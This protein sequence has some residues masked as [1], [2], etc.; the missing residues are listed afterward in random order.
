MGN[1]I[2]ISE[3]WT[4]KLSPLKNHDIIWFYIFL[5]S[6]I[7][8]FYLLH[9]YVNEKP[10][11]GSIYMIDPSFNKLIYAHHG[12][13]IIAQNLTWSEGP[14]WIEADPM[15]YLM[16]SDTVSNKIYRWDEGKG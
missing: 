12:M 16:F 13:E 10:P 8:Y 3:K 2:G 7:G 5:P 1:K 4:N 6:L 15:G 9:S 14:L 11:I